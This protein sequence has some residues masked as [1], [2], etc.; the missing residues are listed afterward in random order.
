MNV[1]SAGSFSKEVPIH[2]KIHTGEKPYECADCGKTF[3]HTAYLIRHKRVHTGEKP[4]KC[5]ECGKAFGMARPAL[6][7]RGFT[8]VRGPMYVIGVERHSEPSHPLIVTK[9][10]ILERNLKTVSLWKTL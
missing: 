2:Q 6:S 5:S 3:T 4:Y 8:Q 9:D 7:I 1:S 10:V